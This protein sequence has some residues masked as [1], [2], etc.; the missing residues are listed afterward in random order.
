VVNFD[1]L[2]V[3]AKNYNTTMAPG[4]TT[5]SDWGT[6]TDVPADAAAVAALTAGAKA[7]SQNPAA[8]KEKLKAAT[9]KRPASVF[10]ARPIAHA[11]AAVAR[12]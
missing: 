1:D 10:S 7:K 9:V 4:D 8:V 5:G 12:R 11:K 2:L 3:L 6:L